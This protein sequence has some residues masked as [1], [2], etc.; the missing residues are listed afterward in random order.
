MKWLLLVVV[1]TVCVQGLLVRVH[2]P[3][4]V[5][6]RRDMALSMASTSTSTSSNATSVDKNRVFNNP[7]YVASPTHV[8]PLRITGSRRKFNATLLLLPE[9]G[10]SWR[11]MARS[12][13]AAAAAATKGDLTMPVTITTS[14]LLQEAATSLHDM[15]MAWTCG[16]W[17]AVTYA[18]WDASQRV[19]LV[20]LS[21]QN[22]NHNSKDNSLQQAV[23][24]IATELHDISSWRHPQGLAYTL[25]QAGQ[26]N[27][28]W[29]RHFKQA[30]GSLANKLLP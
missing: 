8:V 6:G 2:A 28:H 16:D 27:D 18:A 30:A 4:A 15:G 9:D 23:A 3:F 29:A 5:G 24:R 20:A 26:G 13:A 11:N 21:L 14:R 19:E 17:E 7:S 22:Q 12:L 1:I 25:D 10:E